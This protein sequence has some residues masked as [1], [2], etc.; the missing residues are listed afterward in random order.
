MRDLQVNDIQLDEQWSFVGKKK[1]RVTMADPEEFGDNY[2]YIALASQEK[3]VLSYL[4]GKRNEENTRIFL[5]DLRSRIRNRPQVTSDG[6]AA[7]V[8][9][10]ED[11]FGENVDFAQLIKKRRGSAQDQSPFITKLIVT[12]NPDLQKIST[13]Y[14]ERFNGSTRQF[15][16]GRFGR[17]SIAFSKSLENH[18]AAVALWIAFYNFCWTPRTRKETPGQMLG[19][20]NHTW[21]IGELVGHAL[22]LSDTPARILPAKADSTDSEDQQPASPTSATWS[23]RDR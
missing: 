12:G 17:R 11:A 20:T 4:L 23:N 13:S 22:A 16:D 14:V 10:V 2:L 5:C 19:V 18:R 7:Y 3:A 6:Y 1:K 15:L 21:S 9:A 8:E